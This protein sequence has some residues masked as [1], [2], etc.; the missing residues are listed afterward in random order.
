MALMKIVVNSPEATTS[1]SQTAISTQ[2]KDT[3]SLQRC[4]LNCYRE[5]IFFLAS[6][7][8]LLLLIDKHHAKARISLQRCPETD[9]VKT[10]GT[11]GRVTRSEGFSLPGS[12]H[13]GKFPGWFDQ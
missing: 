5:G 4:E 3:R 10:R 11:L 6:I 2:T 13:N 1:I 7:F 8:S 9:S 12:R